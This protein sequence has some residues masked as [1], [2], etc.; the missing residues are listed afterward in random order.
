M[1]KSCDT[2]QGEFS[3]ST[4]H[5]SSVTGKTPPLPQY[6]SF[7]SR[8]FP[9]YSGSSTC[10]A[11]IAKKQDSRIFY[12]QVDIHEKFIENCTS[13]I[14]QSADVLLQKKTSEGD[15]HVEVDRTMIQQEA[16][17]IVRCLTVLKE[18]VA[19][20]DDDHVEERAILPHGR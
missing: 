12:F 18:Y 2:C 8:I 10:N 3:A 4:L 16:T 1:E 17:R 11:N 5:S 15:K 7:I 19:E 6:G 14:R 20:C 9:D 13:R